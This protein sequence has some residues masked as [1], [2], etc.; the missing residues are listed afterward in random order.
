LGIRKSSQCVKIE[1]LAITTRC[2][3]GYLFG[4]KCKCIAYGL[5]DANATS[6]SL[7]SLK[8]QSDLP[9]ISGAKLPM[10]WKRDH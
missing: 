3:R 4:A 7:A 9:F 10:F 5:A 2:S 1:V 6:W 8:I